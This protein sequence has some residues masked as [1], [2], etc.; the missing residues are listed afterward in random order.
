MNA[1]SQ[2]CFWSSHCGMC[3]GWSSIS[4]DGLSC[5]FYYLLKNMCLLKMLSAKEEG[6][7]KH[8]SLIVSCYFSS[9]ARFGR[10]SW[11]LALLYSLILG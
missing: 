7:E 11:P 9:M 4:S 3:S 1:K 10:S 6:Q 2:F 8:S 5:M